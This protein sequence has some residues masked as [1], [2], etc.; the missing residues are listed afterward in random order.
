MTVCLSI[1]IMFLFGVLIAITNHS[2]LSVLLCSG[3]IIFKIVERLVENV[4]YYS[5]SL[6]ILGSKIAVE[7]KPATENVERLQSLI[8]KFRSINVQE[9][10]FIHQKAAAKLSNLYKNTR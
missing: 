6:L 10:N 5:V 8:D 1:G 2:I 3:G 7:A 9:S 4:K